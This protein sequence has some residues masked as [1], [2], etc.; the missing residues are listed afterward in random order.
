[1]DLEDAGCTARYII[2]DRDGKFPTLFDTILADAGI[3]VVLSGI[4]IPRMNSIMERWIQSCRHELLDQTL[5]WNQAHLPYVLH[6]YEQF[7]NTPTTSRHL[8]RSTTP[9]TA[10]ADHRSS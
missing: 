5:I 9:T 3:Q 8:E 7:Y 10:P 4:Q 6:E 1:M 2:R